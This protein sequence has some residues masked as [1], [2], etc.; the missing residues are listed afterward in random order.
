MKL[1]KTGASLVAALVTVLL[2]G[3]LVQAVDFSADMVMTS[4]GKQ[5]VTGKLLMKGLDKMRQEITEQGE[6]GV[7]IIRFDK[8]VAWQLMPENKYIEIPVPVNKNS[9]PPDDFERV[10][11][12]TD[13]V[14]GYF[15]DVIQYVP[16]KSK[17]LPT[18][19]Q[20]IA[21]DLMIGVKIETKD[22]KGKVLE[23]IE[24]RNIQ[25]GPQPD[26]L[27][28]LPAGAQKFALPFNTRAAVEM[29]DTGDRQLHGQTFH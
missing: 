16:K 7:M 2:S 6:T 29:E 24:Y 8:K 3:A 20:W 28:E 12:G 9:P 25:I 14:G 18:I 21:K 15:C 13:T 11:L 27:F 17:T 4:Q 19:T 10:V 22:A 26:A 1:L 23:V 5:V